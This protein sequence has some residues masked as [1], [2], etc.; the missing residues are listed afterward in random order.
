MQHR[1][2]QCDV[3]KKENALDFSVKSQ[4]DWLFSVSICALAGGA[5]VHAGGTLSRL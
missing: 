2:L 5:D 3:G 1:Q 4:G